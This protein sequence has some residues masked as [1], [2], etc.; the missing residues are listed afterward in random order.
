MIEQPTQYGTFKIGPRE[1]LFRRLIERFSE[2]P[3]R[4]PEAFTVGLTG[5]STPKAFYQWCLENEALPR[6]VMEHVVWS[7]SDERAVSLDDPESNFGNARRLLLDPFGVPELQR[8]PWPVQFDP[9]SAALAFEMKW[10]ERFGAG[11]AF[12]LCL[13][14]MGDD[15]HTA[16]LFPE[17][18]LLA[19]DTG[20]FFSPV[21]VPG[22][23]WR[24]TITPLGLSACRNIVLMVTGRGKAE[25]LRAVLEDPPGTYPVQI[26]ANY[27]DRVEWLV[28]DAASAGLDF[29]S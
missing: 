21:E 24:F 22:K 7:V 2:A 12:D 4:A 9:H 3:S 6:A 18:P 19:I 15:G 10:K 25:R 14:G 20:S 23:G 1:E 17:S 27:S 11:Q 29:S 28:D 5:G 16:S 26:M 13:L 8:F